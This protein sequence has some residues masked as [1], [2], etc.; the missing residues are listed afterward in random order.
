MAQATTI[1]G[2][3]D[4]YLRGTV[5]GFLEANGGGAAR[6]VPAS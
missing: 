1:P 6:W 2:I 5:A 3:R 4:N